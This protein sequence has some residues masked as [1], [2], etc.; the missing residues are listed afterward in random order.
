MEESDGKINKSQG[1]GTGRAA[2]DTCMRRFQKTPGVVR[3]GTQ[4]L[5][6]HFHPISLLY[7]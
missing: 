1:D 4:P 5:E 2:W 7:L 3:F 6:H